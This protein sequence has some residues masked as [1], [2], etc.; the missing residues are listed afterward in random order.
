MCYSCVRECPAKAIRIRNGQADVVVERCIGCGSC[1]RVCSQHAKQVRDSITSVRELLARGRNGADG[2]NGT[3]WANGERQAPVVACIAPSFPAEF[4]HVDYQALSGVE[5]RKLV[6]MVRALGFDKVIEV[7]YGADLVAREYRQLIDKHPDRRY[8]ATTC[9]AI[10][11]F[12]E[13]YH[14]ELVMFLAPVVSPMIATARVAHRLYGADARVVFIG[15]C[16]AKKD[17]AAAE[18]YAN[19]IDAALTFMEL[20][21]MFEDA[22]VTAESVEPSD[23]D[24]PHPKRG[25]LFPLKRGILQAAEIKEDLVT[26]DVVAADGGSEFP[27]ALTEFEDGHLDARLL[28]VL[29]CKGGCIMGAGMVSRSPLFSRRAEVSRYVRERLAEREKEQTGPV[30]PIGPIADVELNAWFYPDDQNMPV[31]EQVEIKAILERMGK[32]GPDDELNCGACG[33]GTCREHAIAIFD[34]LAESE[35]CL[36]ATIVRLDEAIRDLGVTNQQLANAQQALVQSEKLASMGQLAAGI[37]HEVNNP[38]GVVLLYS[39]LLLEECQPGS[40]QY[41]DLQKI[42]V[43]ADRCKKIVSGL[44]NFARKNQVDLKPVDL[45][46]FLQACVRALALPDGITTKVD[47][48]LEEHTVELDPDQ[49]MQVFTNLM[50]NSI[51]AM[52]GAGTLTVTATGDADEVQVSVTDTGHGIPKENVKKVFEPFF[53]TKVAGK[54]TGLGLAI[55]Y[56]IVKMHRGAIVVQSNA[57]PK[58][59]PTGTTITV[60]LPRRPGVLNG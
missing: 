31:P 24:P 4:G 19:D 23:F 2:T 30:G 11:L 42:A 1:V 32:H 53:T 58:S 28:E 38:L 14:P 16:I 51:E 27:H 35:M 25:M 29:S 57:D 7:A 10:V 54:G 37:A 56:G 47:C 21:R 22:G 26:G 60:K 59:G 20:R 12:V 5:F 9:P 3:N 52:A 8:I 33:Y 40:E 13:K 48:R 41:E 15:P 39:Q 55:C 44:L 6:G 45:C 50:N 18:R 34:G 36:P 49:M 46:E 43:Q 17:E